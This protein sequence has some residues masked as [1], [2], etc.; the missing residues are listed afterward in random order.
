[1]VTLNIN[2]RDVSVAKG[3]TILDAARNAGDHVP[4]LCHIKGLLPSGACRM[5]VVEVDGRPG[6][7]PSCSYPAEPGMKVRTSSPRVMNARRTIAELLLAS[8]PFPPLL[9]RRFGVLSP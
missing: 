7:I 6:L 3:A 9:R 8:H 4:T 5:C 1:M 2:G